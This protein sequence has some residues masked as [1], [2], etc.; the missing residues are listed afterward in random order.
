MSC[1]RCA[2]VSNTV[3]PVA[4]AGHIEAGWAE[5]RTGGYVGQVCSVCRNCFLRRDGDCAKCENGLLDRA[6]QHPERYEA[7]YRA[8]SYPERVM[9]ELAPIMAGSRDAQVRQAAACYLADPETL[10]HLALN[11]N[12]PLVKATVAANPHTPAATLAGLLQS[13][14]RPIY[15]ATALNPALPVSALEQQA[16]DA[17]KTWLELARRAM[18]PLI[19]QL[20]FRGGGRGGGLRSLL[21]PA[22]IVG[23]YGAAGYQGWRRQRDLSLALNRRQQADS[24]SLPAQSQH[25]P[26]SPRTPPRNRAGLAPA[27]WPAV[28]EELKLAES[29]LEL[30]DDYY[31][32]CFTRADVARMRAGG[33][34]TDHDAEVA[35]YLL[36]QAEQTAARFPGWHG[37][38]LG[39]AEFKQMQEK[40]RCRK[41]GQYAGGE[42][43]QCHYPSRLAALRQPVVETEPGGLAPVDIYAEVQK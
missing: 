29:A 25:L 28:E 26:R 21:L 11:D 22:V 6:R 38:E 32:G 40:L 19:N 42:R 30:A 27:D 12:H 8:G 34:A 18:Q 37:E 7:G 4:G 14:Q 36:E 31:D 3:A 10:S 2:A 1:N 24:F 33:L 15:R 43:H 13:R 20:A 5:T 17:E 9:V 16:K 23:M 39:P 35:G 41:C